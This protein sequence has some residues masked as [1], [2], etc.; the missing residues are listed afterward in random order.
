M[1]KPVIVSGIFGTDT[2]GSF[3]M[4][5]TFCRSADGTF[6]FSI[7]EGGTV[8][9]ERFLDSAGTGAGET[10]S[11]TGGT[12]VVFCGTNSPVC[13]V[14]TVVRC[15]AAG[16]SFI[17][18]GMLAGVFKMFSGVVV[19]TSKVFSTKSFKAGLFAGMPEVLTGSETFSI[20]DK[21]GVAL[22]LSIFFSG[23]PATL[24]AV[25]ETGVFS[26]KGEVDGT[27]FA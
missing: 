23:N 16:L 10:F 5:E 8:A 17:L 22:P 26:G 27:L 6:P 4:K 19:F 25:S 12:F 18:S 3:G 2:V 1:K 21:S 15:T 9:A 24:F 14:K 20:F 13:C 11:D 7:T